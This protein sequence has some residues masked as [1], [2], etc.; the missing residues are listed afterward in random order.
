M[1]NRSAP[2]LAAA[3][4]FLLIVLVGAT[5]FILLSQPPAPSPTASPS[6]GP[7]FTPTAGP[8]SS[9]TLLPT[10]SASLSPT[11]SLLPTDSPSPT[12]EPTIT[13]T[14]S[15]APTPSPTPSPTATLPPTT[16]E[17]RHVTVLGVGLDQRGV[18]GQVQR[19]IKF[20]VD[21]PSLISAQLS[22]VNTGRV[23]MCLL[24]DAANAERECITAHSGTLTRAVFDTG[25]TAWNVTLIG[26]A[27]TPGQFA[28][29]D[30]TFNAASVELR[31]DSFRFNGTSDPHY[32]GF[33]IVFGPNDNG[34][35]FTMHAEFSDGNPYPWHLHVGPDDAEGFDDSGVSAA[36][37]ATTSVDS[38]SVYQVLFE[39]PDPGSAVLLD[40]V[41][42]TWP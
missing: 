12:T 1:N 30:L 19:T 35:D 32:N 21:G 29:L 40:N 7:T 3:L 41:T 38:G 9:A 18:I 8:T 25:R 34:G 11:P 6:G 23:R 26:A 15:P 2:L 16:S 5:I 37:D 17:D 33:E 20:H 39:N 28:T 24:R 22:G 10:S 42:L 36:V 31:L 4:A 14:P 13:P 27:E